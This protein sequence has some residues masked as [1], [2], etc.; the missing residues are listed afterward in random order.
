MLHLL[1]LFIVLALAVGFGTAAAR[2]HRQRLQA[3][4]RATESDPVALAALPAEARETLALIKRGGPFPYPRKDGSTFGNFE[5][6]AA[7]AA[8]AL[9]RIHR[10]DA[11][12]P[13][14]RCRRIVAGSPPETS[15]E[16]YYTDDHYRSFRR[17]RR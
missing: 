3:R 4:A 14:P 13:R 6:P 12:F 17:I 8:W 10:A 7:E 5:A 1:R 11:G 16:Y 2:D 15:G 9:P